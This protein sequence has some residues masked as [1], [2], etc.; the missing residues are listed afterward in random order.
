MNDMS[1]PQA[2]FD[3]IKDAVGANGWLDA[4]EDLESFVTETRGLWRG[5]C[6]MVVSSDR[7]GPVNRPTRLPASERFRTPSWRQLHPCGYRK[8][9]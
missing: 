2:A 9:Y 8:L 7:G 5:E 4:P 1:N 3:A 6:D